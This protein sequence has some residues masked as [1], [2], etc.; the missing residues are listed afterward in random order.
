MSAIADE[1]A[2]VVDE[3]A[4]AGLTATRDPGLVAATVAASGY[5]L[6]VDQ[7]TVTG[8]ALGGGRLHLKVPVRLLGAAPGGPAQLDPVWQAL[9]AAQRVLASP[10]AEPEPRTIAGTTFP[11]YTLTTQR[12]I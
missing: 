3:L 9:P 12:R 10:T 2:A 4:A 6:L 7:P 1:L 5:C 11:G 8:A